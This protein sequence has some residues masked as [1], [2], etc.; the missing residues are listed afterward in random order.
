[1]KAEYLAAVR[2]GLGESGISGDMKAGGGA[3]LGDAEQ[4]PEA[5]GCLHLDGSIQKSEAIGC[6]VYRETDQVIGSGSWT[7]VS[8]SAAQ[9]NDFDLWVSG[10]DITIQRP[11]FY[12]LTGCV[13]WENGSAVTLG[14]R[15]TADGANLAENIQPGSAVVQVSQNVSTAVW[16]DEGQV[17]NLK[18]YQDSVGNLSLYADESGASPCLAAVRVP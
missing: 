1:M 8:F 10:S 14:L 15:L 7:A 9:K 18:V 13:T 17:V 5:P 16:L 3:W 6:R 11:G 12:L 2:D 4:Q